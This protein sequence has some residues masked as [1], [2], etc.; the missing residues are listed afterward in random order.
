[1][2]QCPTCLLFKED[3]EF[4]D[5]VRNNKHCIECLQLK[6]R[7][8]LQDPVHKEQAKIRSANWNA[9]HP[10]EVR[11]RLKKYR[12]QPKTRWQRAKSAAKKRQKEFFLSLEE[13]FVLIE[14]PCYYCDNFLGKKTTT[15]S[16][17][18]RIDNSKGYTIDN[19]IPCCGVCNR[20]RGDALSQQE[21]MIAI[22]AVISFRKRED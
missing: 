17:L 4:Y 13:F 16:G 7:L 2:K 18:D 12:V 6:A 14:Q 10:N 9:Q 11:A 20:I 19:V 8:Y 22:Q 5:D 3:L 15:L 1:M 21:A